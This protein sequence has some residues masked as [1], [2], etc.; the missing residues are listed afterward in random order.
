MHG[1]YLMEA[2]TASV[3]AGRHDRTWL[4]GGKYSNYTKNQS[5]R[6][7]KTGI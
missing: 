1:R 5:I 6:G 2:L 3:R 7:N 4:K